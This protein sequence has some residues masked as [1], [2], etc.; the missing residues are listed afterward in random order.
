MSAKPKLKE[1]EFGYLVPVEW[2]PW[3]GY[4]YR[5]GKSKPGEEKLFFFR[6]LVETLWP[7]PVFIWDDWADLSF[8][9]LCGAQE[10]I[11]RITGKKIECDFKWWRS[12]AFS[13]CGS[14][15]KS[16]RS[17]MWMLCNWLAA[18][19]HTTSIL[20]STSIDA[21]SKRI[22]NCV[23]HWI[24]QASAPLDKGKTA[25]LRSI[26][27]DLE[28]RWNDSDRLH[29]IFGIAVKSG[30]N[31]QEAVDRI[32]GMH[33]PRVF[34][35]VDEATSVPEAII[36]ACRNLNKGTLEY[37]LILLG[38]AIS[39]NDP[40]GERSEPL[41][42]WGSVTVDDKFWITKYGCCVHLDAFDSPA[43][44]DPARFHFY[45]NRENLEDEAR[46]LGGMNSPEA[47]S[48]LRGFWP[49]TGISRA[50]FDEALIEQF[51][52]KSPAVWK[53]DW[54]VG[55]GFDVAMEGGD[56]RVLYPFKFGEFSNGVQGIE[57]LEPII[58]QVDMTQDKRFLP[59]AISDAV[60]NLCK[61]FK[62]NGQS[63]PI[64][65]KHL[66]IDATGEGSAVMGVM[67][68]RWSS[69]II[70]CEFG[71]AAPKTQINQSR[72]TTWYELYHNKV[73][74][75]WYCLRHYM[76]GGQVRG[77]TDVSTLREL[78][79]R[80]RKEK[81]TNG[82]IQ[83]I[84]KPEAKKLLGRSCDL[85]DAAVLAANLLQHLNIA[86]ASIGST[87]GHAVTMDEWNRMVEEHYAEQEP[88]YASA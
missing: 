56:R 22:W 41:D 44:K 40:H 13:G 10:T 88:E 36:K 15:G 70:P 32:K 84:P 26:P 37:Q 74:Y 57:Y 18:R 14:S 33:A 55:A 31:P 61:N 5:F 35:V 65:P 39:R 80:P 52:C 34:V 82:K 54:E 60:E 38:N 73:T 30:G 9:A 51:Q 72:P 76:E 59:Y 42:G 50:V 67:S 43:M 1:I 2:Q 8:G 87:G 68:G 19:E 11:E 23:L 63:R 53:G 85:A 48:N 49:P 47:W 64:L 3:Q 25:L 86:P 58:V 24:S 17:A 83:L 28:V 78:T 45:P 69:E 4:L 46:E 79:S 62:V 12:I 81:E 16:T 71:G 75:L 21:L 6:K 77:L 20:T 7:D 29:A 27:S 66:V